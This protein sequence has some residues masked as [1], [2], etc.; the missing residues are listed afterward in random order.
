MIDFDFGAEQNALRDVARDLFRRQSPPSVIRER[1]KSRERDPKLWRAI[2]EVGLLGVVVP[3][4]YGGSGGDEVDLVLAL[5]EA[6]R[7]A[8]PEPL[9]E[10]TTAARL[11]ALSAPDV[12]KQRWLP[13]LASGEAVA[14]VALET[15]PFV[16]YADIADLILMLDP[17]GARLLTREDFSARAVTSMDPARPLFTVESKRGERLT[18]D[19]PIARAAAAIAAVQN[20]IAM[21]LLEMTVDYVG[22]RKQFGRPVGSFQ[23]VKHKLAR[24]HVAIEASR[25]A[26]WYA[27]YAYATQDEHAARA[28]SVAKVAASDAEAIA[29]AEALQCHGGIGFTWEHDLHIWLKRGLALQGAFGTPAEHRAMLAREEEHA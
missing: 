16:P 10:T 6:G 19:N 4:P 15:D 20:G 2:A 7:A 28:A 21:R 5:E 23:A 22:A 8:L 14:T 25:P 12:L 27:A 13:A 26:A 3:E 24:A 29:N 9:A 1:W 11:I 17:T 18:I